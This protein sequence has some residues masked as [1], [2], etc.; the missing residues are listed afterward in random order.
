[1][2]NF[3]RMKACTSTS[4]NMYFYK[5]NHV[6]LHLR[7]FHLFFQKKKSQ[8]SPSLLTQCLTDAATAAKKEAKRSRCYNTHLF[9]HDSPLTTTRMCMCASVLRFWFTHCSTQIITRQE[10]ARARSSFWLRCHDLA[11]T[12]QVSSDIGLWM[13]AVVCWVAVRFSLSIDHRQKI[14]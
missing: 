4:R 10:S 13:C 7:K 5:Q 2:C 6:I 11:A 3:T 12:R 14:R 1:M 9:G 8:F